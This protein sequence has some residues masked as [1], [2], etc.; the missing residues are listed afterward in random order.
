MPESTVSADKFSISVVICAHNEQDWISKTLASLLKQNRRADEIVVVNNAS[1]D[2]TADAVNRFIADHPGH[3]IR[4]VDEPK[5]GLYLARDAGWRAASGDII[6]TTDADITFPVDWLQIVE[7]AFA[8][9]NVGAITGIV[10]Y[11][12]AH[13]IANWVTVLTDIFFQPQGIGKLLNPKGE[14]YL[15]GGNSAIRRKLL[16][17]ANGYLGKANHEFE[18]RYMSDQIRK[19]GGTIHFVG[20]LKVWHSFRRFKKDGWRGYFKYMFFYTAENVYADHLVEGDPVTV[21]VPAYNEE[22]LIRRCLESLIQQDARA[23]EILVVDNVSTDRTVEIVKQVMAE[24]PEAN[25]KLMHEAKKGCIPAREAG[26]RVASGK[27]IVHVDADETFPPGWMARVRATMIVNP[28]L[29][30]VG[31]TVRFENA[32]PIILLI[33]FLYNRLYPRIVQ[34]TKG[35]P[36]LCGGMTIVRREVL[37]KMNGYA[38]IPNDQL[39]DYYLSAQA[40]KLGFKIRYIPAIYAIHSLRRYESGGLSGF[41]K[42]GVGGLDAAQYDAYD[43]TT[44]TV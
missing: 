23:D 18:D 22:K 41:L 34:W 2:Q 35:F 6:V 28:Q 30:A 16:E 24:H 11:D 26:W 10:R 17:A 7:R 44:K 12:D 38:D 29:A 21:I 14:I 43:T 42:W 5:K 32:P 31:G 33:Q 4:I 1:T 25:I 36:Y 37:E 40:H 20:K 15:N 27:I 13:P 3:N 8:D 39:E 19:V 9:P